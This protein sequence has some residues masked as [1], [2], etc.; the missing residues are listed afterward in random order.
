[1]G[2][3]EKDLGIF[4]YLSPSEINKCLNVR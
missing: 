3:K 2:M 4:K 1:M